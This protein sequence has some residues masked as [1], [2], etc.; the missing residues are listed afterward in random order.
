MTRLFTLILVSGFLLILTACDTTKNTPVES[1][2]PATQTPP[3]KEK[4]FKGYGN[5]PAWTIQID[6]QGIVWSRMGEKDMKYP[7]T[8]PN[9]DG[10]QTIYIS[11]KGEST[12][13]VTLK[14]ER[15]QDTMSGKRYLYENRNRLGRKI[16]FRMCQPHLKGGSPTM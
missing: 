8:T 14:P 3:K 10:N 2:V 9:T 11:K 7:A 1:S 4:A 15:C 16:I 6:D 5:E 13:K 12:L